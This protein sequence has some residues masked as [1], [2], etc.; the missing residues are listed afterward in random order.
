M[1]NN[2]YVIFDLDGT[3][4]NCDHRLPLI[5]NKDGSPRA[6]ARWNDFYEAI[7]QDTVY[8]A[9]TALCRELAYCHKIVYSTSRPCWTSGLTIAWLRRQGL[10]GGDFLLMRPDYDLKTKAAELKERMFMQGLPE[11]AR[12]HCVLAVEDNIEC[13]EM[14]AKLGVQCLLVNKPVR[15]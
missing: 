1:S 14:Y 15:Y 6:D 5:L 7:P 2:G 9:V 12:E 8:P 4:A 3:L 13:A 11:I 10:P